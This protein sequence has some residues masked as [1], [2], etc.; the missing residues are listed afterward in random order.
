MFERYTEKARRA[1]F[2]ARFEASQYGSEFIEPEHLLL[3]LLRENAPE[4]KASYFRES[5]AISDIRAE[6]EKGMEK[7][8]R[9]STS[10]EILLADDS[11]RVLI[12]AAEEAAILSHPLIG[13]DHMLLG[14]L[15]VEDCR[16]AQVLRGKGIELG[17][18][19]DTV[20]LLAQVIR[21]VQ[22]GF[23][24][25][26]ESAVRLFLSAIKQ[27]G[28]DELVQFFLPTA[29]FVDASGRRWAGR[30]EIETGLVELLVPYAK[31][32]SIFHVEEPFIWHQNVCT[33]FVLWENVVRADEAVKPLLRMT[34]FLVQNEQQWKIGFLQVTPVTRDF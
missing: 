14:L 7:H 26:P 8:P 30:A 4:F 12:L 17:N 32:N 31:R 18:V 28:R 15:R 10:I 23:P 33:A 25:S 29:Q 2:F 6:L 22:T 13:P 27:H 3:G 24:E 20:G 21:S 11:K 34:F 1:V 16:A 9:T 5:I 19:R